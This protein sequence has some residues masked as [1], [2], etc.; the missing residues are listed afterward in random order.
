MQMSNGA[1][2]HNH[3]ILTRCSWSRERGGGDRDP[4]DA[5]VDGVHIVPWTGGGSVRGRDSDTPSNTAA[6]FVTEQRMMQLYIEHA[7]TLLYL[8]VCFSRGF[9]N[10]RALKDSRYNRAI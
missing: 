7:C 5:L 2:I 1:L 4:G 6:F 10:R 9:S 3:L 8:R